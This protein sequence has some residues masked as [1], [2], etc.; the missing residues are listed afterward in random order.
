MEMIVTDFKALYAERKALE[1]RLNVADDAQYEQAR[2]ELDALPNV[3]RIRGDR[4]ADFTGAFAKIDKQCARIEKR[5]G[6][7]VPRPEIIWGDKEDVIIERP[8]A[9]PEYVTFHYAQVNGVR[10]EMG[11]WKFVATL[12]HMEGGN[13]IRTVPG[14]EVDLSAYH[15]CPAQCDHCNYSRRRNDTYVVLHETDGLRQV[16]SACLMDYT[17][18]LD[19][20]WCASAAEWKLM[21]DEAAEGD[22]E[23]DSVGGWCKRN[24][25]MLDMLEYACAVVRERGWYGSKD[26]QNYPT[27]RRLMDYAYPPR[28][29]KPEDWGRATVTDGDK[30][31]AQ[32][33]IAWGESLGDSDFEWNVKLI[34]GQTFITDR[35]FGFLAYLPE[36]LRKAQ[37]EAAKLKAE[38]DAK[39][40]GGSDYVGTP[41]QKTTQDVTVI[42]ARRYDNGM[43][44]SH[45]YDFLTDDG[46][47]LIWWATRDQDFKAGERYRI[48]GTVKNHNEYKGVKQTS[49]LRCKVEHI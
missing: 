22:E 44:V 16:G 1:H 17:G 5:T 26:D 13:V 20:K 7:V 23:R 46:N 8:D 25:D 2:K 48:T 21:L 38:A 30:D 9:A 24:F 42:G 19:P 43:R 27:K 18:G 40:V 11:G 14:M 49:L 15:N 29:V 47:A 28:G 31:T 3:Y 45:I 35:H 41:G 4:M 12:E 36:G 39:G 37:A 33:V 10:P 32:A 6:I 34:L